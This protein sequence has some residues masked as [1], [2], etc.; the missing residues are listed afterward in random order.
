MGAGPS[1]N[2]LEERVGNGC[3]ERLGGRG[4]RRDPEGVAVPPGILSGDE[5]LFAGNA[6]RQ[7]APLLLE[8]SEPAGHCRRVGTPGFDLRSR[9]I[10]EAPEK[11]VECVGGAGA[12]RLR[13]RLKLELYLVDCFGR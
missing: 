13:E 2:E 3:K 5:P 11:V 1:A 9:E 6:H 7:R 8:V 12:E 10:A 4:G